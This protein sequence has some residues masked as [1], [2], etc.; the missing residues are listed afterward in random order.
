M[1]KQCP[2]NTKNCLI[3]HF[4][5]YDAF[6]DCIHQLLSVIVRIGHLNI[7]SSICGRRCLIHAPVK[8]GQGESIKLPLPFQ[9]IPDQ[10][11]VMTTD[12]TLITI[13][14]SHDGTCT[15]INTLLK[16]RQKDLSFC[17]L[18][19]GNIHLKPCILHRIKRKVLDAGND[20]PLLPP[21]Y[22]SR[23]HVPCQAWVFPIRFLN[24]SPARMIREIHADSPKQV[25]SG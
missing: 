10:V 22:H 24:P 19:T 21:A 11:S 8:I 20:A 3:D 5:F 16:L 23:A 6:S 12:R 7:L 2:D 13:V 4:F 15:C 25:T 17:T 14:R 1:R 18:V 9:H